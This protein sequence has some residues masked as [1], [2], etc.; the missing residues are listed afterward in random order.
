MPFFGNNSVDLFEFAR[1]CGPKFLLVL[2]ALIPALVSI[3]VCQ[4]FSKTL[5]LQSHGYPGAAVSISN[6]GMS[7]GSI[8]FYQLENRWLEIKL[9]LKGS[10]QWRVSG[11][12][13]SSEIEETLVWLRC[14]AKENGLELVCKK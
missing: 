13:Y 10:N 5:D 14:Y 9:V 4:N 8:I 11:F 6:F 12:F 2:R 1:E 7:R 3:Q